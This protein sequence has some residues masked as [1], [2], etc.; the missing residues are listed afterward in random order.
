MASPAGS[1]HYEKLHIPIKHWKIYLGLKGIGTS[2]KEKL[3]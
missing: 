3:A 1:A 2:K